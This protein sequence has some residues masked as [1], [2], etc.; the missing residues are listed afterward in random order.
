MGTEASIG[1]GVDA[2]IGGGGDERGGGGV[3]VASSGDPP[4]L[5]G[6][7]ASGTGCASTTGIVVGIPSSGR[8]GAIESGTI[9]LSLF[10]QMRDPL[11]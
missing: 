3:V 4:S 9:A 7:R 2:S 8:S 1:G 5:E 10:E 11:G 6:A